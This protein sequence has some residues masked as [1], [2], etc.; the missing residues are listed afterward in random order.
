MSKDNR[1]LNAEAHERLPQE[2]GLRRR[3]PRGAA[4]PIAVPETGSVEGDNAIPSF[5]REVE[6]TAEVEILGGDDIAVDQD[7][8]R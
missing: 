5:G 8:R 6:H 7:H 4:R 3:R 2:V 1:A